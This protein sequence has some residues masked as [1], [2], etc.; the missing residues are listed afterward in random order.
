MFCCKGTSMYVHG[1]FGTS[2]LSIL[3]TFICMQKYIQSYF[4]NIVALLSERPKKLFG[5]PLNV[6]IAEGMK[7]VFTNP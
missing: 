6:P 1:T 3:R 2:V 4:L 5:R 7:T